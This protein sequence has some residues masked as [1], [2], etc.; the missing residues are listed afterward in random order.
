MK[1]IYLTDETKGLSP[2]EVNQALEALLAQFPHVKKVLIIPPDFTR[3]Y[4]YAGEL[5]RMLYEKLSPRAVV[6]I[7]PALGTHMEM[8]KEEKEKMFGKDIPDGA[9]LV[10]H[11]QT[12]TISIGTVPKEVIEEISQGLY[13]TEIEVEVNEKLINGSYDL[14]LSVGQVVPHEVVGMANYSKN[15]FV[16]VGGRQMINKSHMLSAICGMEKALG[17][18]DSPARKVFDYAQQ[19]FLD[20]RLPLVYLQTVTTLKKEEVCLNGLYIGSSRKP[21]EHGVALST[22]LNICHVARRAKKLVTYLDPCEL[23]TTWVGNKGIYRTRMAVADGGD[24][25]ILAPGV[26]SFGENEEMDQMT[27]TYGYK[28]RD[29]VLELFRKGVFENRIMAA[30][31]LIQGSSDGRFRITYCTRPENLSKED[32]N[33][34][35]YDWMDYEEAAKLYN[36]ETLKEG[37]NTLENGE[38]IYFVKTPALGLWKADGVSPKCL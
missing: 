31:H 32:I 17:V 33:R 29:Y 24:L 16:G 28:G 9:F 34:V 26:K 4:S 25:I 14:I 10:H 13:S 6:H 8:D 36:P 21:F 1:E 2:K 19:H 12:D 38:E 23:K 11:W 20:G 5:T 3:C 18:A 22:K 15:I 27:R 37:W 35:G 7:M 30:A